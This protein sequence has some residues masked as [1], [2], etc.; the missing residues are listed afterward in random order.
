M[1]QTQVITAR[2]DMEPMGMMAIMAG[3][4]MDPKVTGRMLE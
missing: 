2:F 4:Q 1:A 3:G